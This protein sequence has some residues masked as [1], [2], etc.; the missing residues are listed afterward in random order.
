MKRLDQLSEGYPLLETPYIKIKDGPYVSAQPSLI[1]DKL[2][3]Q[4]RDELGIYKLRPEHNLYNLD[5][6]I[7]VHTYRVAR[8]GLRLSVLNG[9]HKSHRQN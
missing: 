1:P 2:P 8:N 6:A 4:L 9:A 5:G 7:I 3:N